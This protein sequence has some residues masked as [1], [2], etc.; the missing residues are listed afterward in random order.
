MTEFAVRGEWEQEPD[1]EEF[2]HAE[3]PC[4]L[5][6]HPDLGHLCGYVGVPPAHPC[7]GKGYDDVEVEVHGGLTFA[8]EG[9]GRPE[10]PEDFWRFGFDCAHYG[11]Y[12]PPTD[13]RAQAIHLEVTGRIGPRSDEIYRNW[14]YVRQETEHLAEQLGQMMQPPSYEE[15]KKQLV[16]P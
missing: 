3:L 5:L 8:R 11:D 15:W 4:R 12:S 2:V 1:K 7:S 16:G 6:R 13:E 10:L 9:G 14:S